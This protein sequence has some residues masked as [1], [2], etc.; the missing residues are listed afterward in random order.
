MRAALIGGAALALAGCAM[1]AAGPDAPAAT[2][3]PKAVAAY[4]PA[5]IADGSLAGGPW[6]AEAID[7]GGVPDGTRVELTFEGGDAGTG[8]VS[9][10]TGCN[11]ASGA[12][13][14]QGA[15]LRL[16]PL[17]GTRMMCPPAQM[18]IEN[19]VLGVLN[20]AVAVRHDAAG[21][22]TLRTAD[23]RTLTM[24]RVQ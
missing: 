9:G 10:R 5:A 7:G 20:G 13:T 19:K 6:L 11:R 2:A 22:A 21:R 16:G 15:G 18:D 24:R 4:P 12:W 14:Q 1:N 17:A 23:G 8:R 3:L